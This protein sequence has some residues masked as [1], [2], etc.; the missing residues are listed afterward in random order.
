[1]HT[2]NCVSLQSLCPTH[3]TDGAYVPSK[4][5]VFFENVMALKEAREQND[6]FPP[7]FLYELGV[8]SRGCEDNQ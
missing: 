5:F 6:T 7:A 4:P 3:A 1:M 2:Q 8:A